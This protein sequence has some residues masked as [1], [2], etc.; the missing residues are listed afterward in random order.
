MYFIINHGSEN[1]NNP[2]LLKISILSDF[3]IKIPFDFDTVFYFYLYWKMDAWFIEFK[4]IYLH[5]YVKSNDA[6]C[7]F[8]I[9]NWLW[10]NGEGKPYFLQSAVS[11]YSSNEKKGYKIYDIIFLWHIQ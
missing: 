5:F 4:D 2:V 6:V 8:K 3:N 11:L 9:K 10:Q 7:I 1:E